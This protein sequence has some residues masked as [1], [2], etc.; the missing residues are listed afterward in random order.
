MCAPGDQ[1]KSSDNQPEL[2]ALNVLRCQLW[3]DVS[4]GRDLV[5]HLSA[6]V[7]RFRDVRGEDREGRSATKSDSHAVVRPKGV[8]ATHVEN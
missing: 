2:A 6:L 5:R 3:A 7:T 8:D 1:R 4:E